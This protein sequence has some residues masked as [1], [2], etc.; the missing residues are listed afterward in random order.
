M[1]SALALGVG[2][3]A[4]MA[5]WPGRPPIGRGAVSPCDGILDVVWARMW[6]A[7][8]HG[9]YIALSLPECAPGRHVCFFCVRSVV[10]S[11]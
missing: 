5:L 3:G 6:G 8:S 2:V 11:R 7:P 1:W 4:V 10:K 9:R